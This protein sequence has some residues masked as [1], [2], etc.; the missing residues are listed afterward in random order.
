MKP[1]R[2]RVKCPVRSCVSSVVDLGKHLQ[3]VHKWSSENAS[4][5]RQNF[6]LRK[7]M[8]R[9]P[10]GQR[11]SKKRYYKRRVCPDMSCGKVVVRLENHLRQYH[12]IQD[13]HEGKKLLKIAAFDVSGE[14][15]EVLLDEHYQTLSED[16]NDDAHCHYIESE[17]LREK[18]RKKD[19]EDNSDKSDNRSA[20]LFSDSISNN[21]SEEEDDDPDWLDV[22]KDR[23]SCQKKRDIS[24]NNVDKAVTYTKKKMPQNHLSENDS[25]AHL[26][27]G[28]EVNSDAAKL[29]LVDKNIGDENDG[30]GEGG[31]DDGDDGDEGYGGDWDWVEEE[32]EEDEDNGNGTTGQSEQAA[33]ISTPVD[34]MLDDWKEWFM[35]PDGGNKQERDAKHHTRQV[36]KVINAVGSVKNIFD[37]DL[38]WKEWLEPFE[39]I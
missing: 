22:E 16:E 35:S 2:D 23:V 11:K 4:S 39:K 12:K 9:L 19:A 8:R 17:W 13:P 36:G 38:L 32:D 15:N 10:D 14:E 5:A 33:C 24:V 21:V 27:D 30:D 25:P 29:G 18:F 37:K 28:I 1:K 20:P 6:G 31:G 26:H 3:N 34:R 7:P